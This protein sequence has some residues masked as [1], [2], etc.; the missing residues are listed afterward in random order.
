VKQIQLSPAVESSINKLVALFNAEAKIDRKRGRSNAHLSIEGKDTLHI[1][2]S[3]LAEHCGGKRIACMDF[4]FSFLVK[5]LTQALTPQVHCL[6]RP[7]NSFDRAI[8]FVYF[9]WAKLLPPQV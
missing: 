2:N 7:C 9:F 4:K 1:V 6:S 3:A 8:H 5:K